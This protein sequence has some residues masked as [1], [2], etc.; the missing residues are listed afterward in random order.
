MQ[1]IWSESD[2]NFIENLTYSETFT[3][4]SQARLF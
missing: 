1:Q 4:F 2:E 3:F